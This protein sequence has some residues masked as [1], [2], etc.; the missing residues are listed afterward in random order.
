MTALSFPVAIPIGPWA[1]GPHIVF[2]TLA[3]LVGFRL[4][5]WRRRRF[6]DHVDDGPRWS[7]VTAAAVGAVVGSRLLYWL[8]DP[9]ATLEHF[10]HPTVLLAG[11]TVVGALLGGW[12]AVEIVK[13]FIGVREATGDLFAIPLAVGMSIGRI[14]CFLSG[15]PDGTYGTQ[16]SLPW[17]VDFGD[18]IRRHPAA[19]YESLFMLGL[20]LVLAKAGPSLR[21][22]ESFK[23][24]MAAYL[25]F[26]LVVDAIKPGVPLALGLTAIQWASVAGLA[27]YAWWVTVRRNGPLRPQEA[28]T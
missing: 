8:E 10:R 15:L 24:F 16:T 13:R 17:G 18:G 28:R 11:K 9:A 6:G 3:Y 12:I 20:A 26:R 7:I 2:E 23:L 5:L 4:Y 22:G 27:Y 21:R 25:A 14:G 19:I 1:L